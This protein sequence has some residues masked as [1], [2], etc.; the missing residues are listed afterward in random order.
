[1]KQKDIAAI[2]GVTEAMV[3]QVISGK[4]FSSRIWETILRLVGPRRKR[5]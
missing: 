2:C 5:G 1:M 3:S 4:L